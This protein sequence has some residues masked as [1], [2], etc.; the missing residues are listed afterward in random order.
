MKRFLPLMIFLFACLAAQPAAAQQY[1]EKGDI[2]LAAS[3]QGGQTEIMVPI[4]VTSQITVAPLLGFT[5]R[6]NGANTLR[7]GLKSK[8]YTSIGEGAATFL[9]LQ[10]AV[11]NTDP[12]FG[13]SDSDLFLGIVGGGDYFFNH[14]FS[15]GV[16]GQ[17]NFF[18]GEN[19]VISTGAGVSA[20]YYF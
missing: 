6:E 16:E 5:A 13:E 11:D 19:Q 20:A 14:H 8:Y 15:I 18:L 4:W 10:A 3:L 9:G 2:G 7:V 12:E 1:P 17:L